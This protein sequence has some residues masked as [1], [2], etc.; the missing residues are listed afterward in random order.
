MHQVFDTLHGVVDV[1]TF[2]INGQTFMGFAEH[3]SNADCSNSGLGDGSSTPMGV[4]TCQN[5]QVSSHLY[6]YDRFIDNPRGDCKSDETVPNCESYTGEFRL[7]QAF[8]TNGARKMHYFSVRT[9]GEVLHFLAIAEHYDDSAIYKWN[10][11]Q[12]GLFQRI[13]TDFAD[14]LDT[15]T[16]DTKTF[17]VVA[18]RGCADIE[19]RDEAEMCQSTAEKGRAR[20]YFYN[21]FTGEFELQ[22]EGEQVGHLHAF[23]ADFESF[24]E[25]EDA[26]NMFTAQPVGV[27]AFQLPTFD[28]I[29]LGDPISYIAVANNRIKMTD[30]IGFCPN[31]NHAFCSAPQSMFTVATSVTEVA[32]R[33]FF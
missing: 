12:F 22:D 4:P 23:G 19:R 16:E 30:E 7:L 18:N 9:T 10:G 32:S 1:E 21:P 31:A 13:Q 20:V 33:R 3:V 27:T 11:Q 6:V 28:F 15:F 14:D 2:E 26:L 17:L 8:E 25:V 5:F 24:T 29:S